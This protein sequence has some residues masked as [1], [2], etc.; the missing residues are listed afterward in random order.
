MQVK[1]SGKP[2]EGPDVCLAFKIEAAFLWFMDVPW[3]IRFNGIQSASFQLQQ[4]ILPIFRH[5]PKIM[6]CTG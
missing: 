3:D 4:T 6:K 2:D 1:L 5:N